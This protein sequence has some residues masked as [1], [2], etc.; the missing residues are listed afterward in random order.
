MSPAELG[1][2][3]EQLKAFLAR[4]ETITSPTNTMGS[5]TGGP[6]R[7]S[8]WP[9]GLA[10]EKPFATLEEFIAHYRWMHARLPKEV[11]IRFAHADLVPKNI[12]VEG[13]TI[14]GTVDWALS[15]FF[16]DFGEYG[17]MHDPVEMTRGWDYV[18]QKVFPGP[19]REA[20][21][22][23]V[24]Q[25]IRIRFTVLSVLFSSV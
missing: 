4:M 18:L 10:P 8:F 12:I 2:I 19:R 1:H 15:G 20:E 25:L 5:V 6:Y 24:R 3:A 13:S 23:S 9:D 22:N 7:N 11:T 17:R 21:I 16:P 14:T